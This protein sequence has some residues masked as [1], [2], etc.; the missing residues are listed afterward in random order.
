MTTLP[1]ASFPSKNAALPWPHN[2]ALPLASLIVVLAVV[3]KSV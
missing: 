3:V 1:L 2:A